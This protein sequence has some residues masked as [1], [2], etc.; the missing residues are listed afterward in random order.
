MLDAIAQRPMQGANGI[1]GVGTRVRKPNGKTTTIKLLM[2]ILEPSRG[3]A[4]I[5]GVDSRRLTSRE[6]SRIGY[7]SENQELPQALR[8]GEYLSYLRPFYPKWDLCLERTIVKIFRLPLDRK[9][10][11]FSHG[12]RMKTALTCALCYHPEL[13]ILDE[14]FN[15]LDPLIRD[16]F[17]EGLL[18]QAGQITVFMSTHDLSDI[19]SFATG[20]TFMDSSG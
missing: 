5:F 7:V 4:T 1:V 18:H 8:L 19:E 11:H 3:S 12:M 14:P 20:I 16:E 2:N 15:G 17:I 10:S 9:I 6:L 13:L